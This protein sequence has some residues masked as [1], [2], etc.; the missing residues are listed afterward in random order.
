MFENINPLDRSTAS[1]EIFLLM[2]VSFLIGYFFSRWYYINKYK[3]NEIARDTE[4]E[5]IN[6]MNSEHANTTFSEGGIKAIKTRERKGELV[7]PTPT[8]TSRIKKEKPLLNFDSIGNAT[9]ADKNDLKMI[10]G[11]G[12]FIEKKL[13]SIGIYTFDQI[14]RLSKQDIV[15]ITELIQFFPGRIERDNWVEQAKKLLQ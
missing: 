1:L 2:L 7:N 14:S 8:T 13:N 4:Q 11:I 5:H 10:N 15:D 3:R 12:P 9:E 6:T